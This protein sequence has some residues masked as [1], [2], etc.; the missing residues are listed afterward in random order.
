LD[1]KDIDERTN[2]EVIED[3]DEVERK[4]DHKNFRTLM[5]KK[6]KE[7]REK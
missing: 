5:E 4:I 6:E 3:E 7:E 2:K 1:V